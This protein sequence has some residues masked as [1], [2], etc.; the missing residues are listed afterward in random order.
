MFHDKSYFIIGKIEQKELGIII[1]SPITKQKQQK[2]AVAFV[3]DTD[4]TISGN[5]A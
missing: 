2:I 3:D 4:F 5:N 1:E